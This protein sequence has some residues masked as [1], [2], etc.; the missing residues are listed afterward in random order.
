VP[1]AEQGRSDSK[2]PLQ[3]ARAAG[4]DSLFTVHPRE[5]ISARNALA[6]GLKKA[7]DKEASAAVRRLA[8]PTV[9]VWVVNQVARRKGAE[10]EELLEVAR[11]LGAMQQGQG[12]DLR[13]WSER[14]R[15]LIR[16]LRAEAGRV[17]ELPATSTSGNLDRAEATLLA[18][19]AGTEAQREALQR[20][21]LQ[22]EVEASGFA[23]FGLGGAGGTAAASQAVAPEPASKATGADRK[24]STAAPSGK[25]KGAKGGA[26][27]GAA[28]AREKAQAAADAARV[29]R[30]AEKQALEEARAAEAREALDRAEREEAAAAQTLAKSEAAYRSAEERFAEAKAALEEAKEARDTAG[31]E[32]RKAAAVVARLSR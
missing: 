7:G 5:F 18:A 24:V 6:D 28:T 9:P 2:D 32:H 14:H 12:G 21:E 16:T 4:L 8:K 27:S 25:G 20:G 22:E 1:K 13:A 30:E 11:K 26:S 19:S 31:A 23:V 15:E 10:V 17:L 29:A 3:R